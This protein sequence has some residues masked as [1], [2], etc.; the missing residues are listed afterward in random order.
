[1]QIRIGAWRFS[2]ELHLMSSTGRCCLDL[3]VK[4]WADGALPHIHTWLG[5]EL[6]HNQILTMVIFLLVWEIGQVVPVSCQCLGD[7]VW[8]EFHQQ[9]CTVSHLPV[10]FLR[11]FDDGLQVILEGG[12]VFGEAK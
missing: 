7:K 4:H 6:N 3:I 2:H 12:E 11:V 8:I 5:G 9:V 1:M 10:V